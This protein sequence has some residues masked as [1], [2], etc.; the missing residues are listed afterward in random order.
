MRFFST[1]FLLAT[2]AFAFTSLSSIEEIQSDATDGCQR[3]YGSKIVSCG[4]ELPGACNAKCKDALTRLSND[5]ILACRFTEEST[6]LLKT[7]MSGGLVRA[8]CSGGSQSID[9]DSTLVVTVSTRTQQQIAQ[10]TGT[11]AIDAESVGPRPTDG[12]LALAPP[13]SNE[14]TTLQKS[15][16]TGSPS[17]STSNSNNQPADANGSL[18]GSTENQN[19]AGNRITGTLR[20]TAAV[21]LLGMIAVAFV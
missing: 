17:S 11:L 20:N 8:M 4:E 21:A 10:V 19:S 7:I 6:G 1:L 13:A 12:G 18:F 9:D 14:P 3:A 2:P 5:I 15:T 16:P